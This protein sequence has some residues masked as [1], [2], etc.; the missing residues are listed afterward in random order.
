V[1]A[2]V[3]RVLLSMPRMRAEGMSRQKALT[4]QCVCPGR[5]P[6]GAR[7]I[8]RN[9]SPAP[10]QVA[11]EDG[12]AREKG[13]GGVPCATCTPRHAHSRV[14]VPRRW[15][16]HFLN[17]GVCAAGD[18]LGKFGMESVQDESAKV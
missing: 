10:G 14:L 16:R 1:C 11:D 18:M 13:R 8:Q 6:A 5:R 7:D 3:S 9:S 17:A 15:G 2:F 12:A 4:C